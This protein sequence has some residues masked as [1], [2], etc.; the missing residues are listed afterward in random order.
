MCIAAVNPKL[1]YEPNM[2]PGTCDYYLPNDSVFNR[3]LFVINFY[4]RNGAR[5]SRHRSFEALLAGTPA[6]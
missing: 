2:P 3:F 6:G 5:D 4:A 1:G